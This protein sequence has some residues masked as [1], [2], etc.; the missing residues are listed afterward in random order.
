MKSLMSPLLIGVMAVALTACGSNDEGKK[1]ANA[2]D[3]TKSAQTEQQQDQAKQMEAM[4]KKLEKQKTDDKKTVAVV[5]NEKLTGSDYN[6]V[7]TSAQTQYQQSG[8]DPTSKDA[9]KQ[10]KKQTINSLVG[11]TLLLQ[12]ANKKGYKASDKEVDKQLA[13]SK[14]Q[15]KSDKE[16]NA[17]LKKA[18]LNTTKLKSELA[19]NIKYEK[20]V[21]KEVP[22]D[23]VTDKEVKDYY[24]Q[25]AAKQGSS[26]GQKLPKLSEVKT[27]IKQQLEQQKQQEKLVKQV[28]KLKKNAK[29]E[30]N[31]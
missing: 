26:E 18:G 2:A 8:Q 11:Q 15:Y 19:D 3:Q 13:E 16:F 1:E 25:Y 17:A 6:S 28:E 31:I 7:L 24:D 14:K 9:A 30:I 29:V 22:K 4:Q 12:E 10:I 21:E 20:Y 5:N 23:K 27:Q